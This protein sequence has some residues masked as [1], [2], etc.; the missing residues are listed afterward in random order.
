MNKIVMPASSRGTGICAYAGGMLLAFCIVLSGG[1]EACHS[2]EP[3]SKA[4]QCQPTTFSLLVANARLHHS[5]QVFARQLALP[6]ITTPDKSTLRLGEKVSV[7]IGRRNPLSNRQRESL[8]G[9]FDVP[10]GV[11]D[12][13]LDRLTNHT[14]L[15]AAQAAEEFRAAVID[16]KYL[17]EKLARYVAPTG[18]E[19]IKTNALQALH[20]GEIDKGWETYLAL[21]RPQPPS[22]LRIVRDN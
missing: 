10:V 19:I 2:E 4:E 5:Y 21:P 7:D 18:K 15:D 9:Q 12:K 17:E 22:G 1:P 16:Y 6:P 11:I 13:T 14:R 20:I 3:G 8:A